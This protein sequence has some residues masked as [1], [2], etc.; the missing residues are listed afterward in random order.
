MDA[1]TIQCSDFIK[2][3]RRHI[4][5]KIQAGYII[6]RYL[7]RIAKCPIQI[8]INW[9]AFHDHWRLTVSWAKAL[10]GC[11]VRQGFI[12]IKYDI[13]VV[14]EVYIRLT[15]KVLDEMIPLLFRKGFLLDGSHTESERNMIRETAS[16]RVGFFII[17][18]E[19]PQLDVKRKK[20]V[21]QWLLSVTRSVRIPNSNT[22]PGDLLVCA[23]ILRPIT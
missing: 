14:R 13:M 21:M 12:L 18:F 1:V 2:S 7:Q 4:S 10:V 20:C 9:F 5:G 11:S 8:G 16:I 17:L 19:W 22:T 23:L 3:R 6:H 15:F